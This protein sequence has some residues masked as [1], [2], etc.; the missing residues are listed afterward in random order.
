MESVDDV[1][2]NDD[3]SICVVE[4]D[5]EEDEDIEIDDDIYFSY[6]E[7][8]VDD[9]AV[10]NSFVTFTNEVMPI[11]CKVRSKLIHDCTKGG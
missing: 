4:G 11:Y 9:D 10:S 6:D 1:A 8:G 7:S 2:S 5:G 3:D